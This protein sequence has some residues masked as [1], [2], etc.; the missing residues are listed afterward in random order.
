[1][2][3]WRQPE[4]TGQVEGGGVAGPLEGP[5]AGGSPL[6]G[7]APPPLVSAR[8]WQAAISNADN[9][10][11]QEV[12][13]EIR[14]TSIAAKSHEPCPKASVAVPQ[15]ATNGDVEINASWDLR[16][17]LG[18]DCPWSSPRS[19]R[20]RYPRLRRARRNRRGS[21]GRRRRARASRRSGACA[22]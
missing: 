4:G 14:R 12:G 9:K 18:C 15:N 1:M 5:G 21:R 6:G 11:R 13:R 22:A 3:S 16:S 20:G 19:R 2:V 17:W 7:A 10:R 8:G